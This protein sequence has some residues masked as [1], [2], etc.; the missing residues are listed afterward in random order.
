MSAEPNL[1]RRLREAAQEIVDREPIVIDGETGD[2]WCL[3]C[4]ASY[5][6]AKHEPWCS[7]TLLRDA[8]REAPR[9]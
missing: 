8:L 9:V 7:W 3:Y 1:E 2:E 6:K 4:D 5:P